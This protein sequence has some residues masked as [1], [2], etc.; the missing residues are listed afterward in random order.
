[1]FVLNFSTTNNHVCDQFPAETC[2]ELVDIYS[3]ANAGFLAL[4]KLMH[5]NVLIS[6]VL[7]HVLTTVSKLF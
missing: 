4:I 5:S 6:P 7:L 3:S 2:S 1:M